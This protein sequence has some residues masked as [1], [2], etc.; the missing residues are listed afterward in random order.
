MRALV[1]DDI[2]FNQ[3]L[4]VNFLKGIAGCDTARTGKEAIDLFRTALQENR[5]YALIFMDI[6]MPEMDGPETLKNIRQLEKDFNVQPGNEAKAIMVTVLSDVKN[7]TRSYFHGLADAYLTKPVTKEK[8]IST[9]KNLG[10]LQ[11]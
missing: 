4:L 11:D 3:M 9:L 6:M 1:V 5:P 10:I 2:E 8:I 7:V